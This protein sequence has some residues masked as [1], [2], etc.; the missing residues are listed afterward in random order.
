MAGRQDSLLAYLQL[1]ASRPTIRG[2]GGNERILASEG[3]KV[4]SAQADHS[5]LQHG[6]ART[7]ARFRD[8][9]QS[10]LTGFCTTRT[11]ILISCFQIVDSGR[12]RTKNVRALIVAEV[13]EVVAKD[14]PPLRVSA[15]YETYR[16]I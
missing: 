4:H 10:R 13:R 3:F 16:P 14:L 15:G 8:V 6:F 2:Q 1:Q 11:I 7:L 5:D 9:D 12:R